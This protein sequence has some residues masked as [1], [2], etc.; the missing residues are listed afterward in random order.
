MIIDGKAIAEQI[1]NEV[2]ALA[3]QTTGRK[4][5]LAVLLVGKNPASHIYVR[6]KTQACENVGMLSLKK[7]LPDSITETELLREV[8]ALNDDPTVDGILVQLPLPK[9]INPLKIMLAIDPEKDVDGFHPIN[10]GKLLIGETDGF[11]PC[12]PYGVKVL[13]ERSGVEVAGKHALII[14]RSNIVGKPMA[15]LLM[16]NTP[17]GNAT[18]TIAHSHTKNMKEL[19]RMADIIIVA[20]GKPR[21]V[22][23]DMVS[24]GAVLIDVGINKIDNPSRK[25]GYQLV[26]DADFDNLKHKC[27]LITPVPGG[28]GPMTIAMLI[29][30]TWKSFRQRTGLLLITL[31]ACIAAG[32]HSS[33]NSTYSI[34]TFTGNAMTITYKVTVGGALTQKQNQDI[35]HIIS[36]VFSDID[37]TYNKWN[38]ESELSR[39]NRAKRNTK[40]PISPDLEKFL[41][42]TGELVALTNGRFDP[43]VEPLQALWKH[44]LEHGRLPTPLEIAAITPAVGWHNIHIADGIFS[45]DD[46][47]TMLD[48][49]GIAKGYA[50]DLLT[51]RLNAAGYPD[52][53]VE[54]GGEIR[55]SGQHPSGRPWNVFISRL[56]N[57]DPTQA[58]AHLHLKDQAIATSGDYL[59]FWTVDGRRY[60]HII[61]PRLKIPLTIGEHTVASAS[62]LADTCA[63]ADALATAAMTFQTASE[64]E[65]WAEAIRNSYPN[66]SFWIVSR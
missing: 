63:F 25:E 24:E 5:C 55:A 36:R 10:V 14:G 20:I 62:V 15:A 26:G 12:T 61:D 47:Y 35:R 66:V 46:D 64:A 17:G 41:Q 39:L 6:R 43:T 21:Y 23:A 11:F 42:Q 44:R 4:P 49:G 51:E 65:Q 37:N 34:A 13:L 59:Q 7:E 28:V 29:S 31:M 60:F 22:T 57:T 8:K 18:V 1:Q 33:D 40:I 54:W 3:S 30:N 48:L 9:Q 52:V 27:S 45:K 58:I 56:E 2:K 32:C 16:Q 53:Y 19:C 38:P 50:V